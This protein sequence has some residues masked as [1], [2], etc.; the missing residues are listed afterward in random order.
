MQ[1]SDDQVAEVERRITDFSRT[2]LSLGDT[3]QR[4]PYFGV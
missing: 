3:R 4:L 2:F 1:L